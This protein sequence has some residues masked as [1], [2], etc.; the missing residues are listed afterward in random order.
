MGGDTEGFHSCIEQLFRAVRAYRYVIA[1]LILI[2]AP[3]CIDSSEVGRGSDLALVMKYLHSTKEY[4]HECNNRIYV[5]L[6]LRLS[7]FNCEYCMEDFEVTCDE[8]GKLKESTPDLVIQG[9]VKVEANIGGEA[10][11]RLRRWIGAMNLHFTIR[12]APD[13]IFNNSGFVRSS[14]AV[15][16]ENGG[17]LFKSDFPVGYQVKDMREIIIGEHNDVAKE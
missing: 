1:S 5:L 17:L 15:M 4:D 3:A 9:L 7:D 16:R 13:S 2:A 6:F 8:L 10:N 14:I 12:Y 11:E